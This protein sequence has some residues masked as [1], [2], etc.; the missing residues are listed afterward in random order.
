MVYHYKDFPNKLLYS[1]SRWAIVTKERL[2]SEFFARES[3]EG[4]EN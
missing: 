1:V 3:K 2:E 4:N